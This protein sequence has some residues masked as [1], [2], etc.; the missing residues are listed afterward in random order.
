M[1]VVGLGRVGGA[2][3]ARARARGVEVEAVGRDGGSFGGASPILVA[4]RNDDLPAVIARIPESRRRDLVLVQNGMLRTFLAEQ[5]LAGVTRGLLFFAVPTRG[6][7]LSGGAPSPFAGPRAGD[8]VAWLARIDVA[9]IEVEAAAFAAVEAEKLLWN[10][11]YGLLSQA[12]GLPVGRVADER[13]D[14]VLALVTELVPLLVPALG[15]LPDAGALAERVAAYS[16]SIPGWMG[17]VKERPWRNGWFEAE[18]ERRRVPT[19]LHTAWLARV[20]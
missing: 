5:G 18:A 10:T 15:P 16:R 13:G 7:D 20:G 12:T 4:T 19:P 14:D 2:L 11:V 17:A 8:V 3:V 9:A 6:V 1:I